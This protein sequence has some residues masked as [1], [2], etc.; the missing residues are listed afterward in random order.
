[1]W[2]DLKPSDW[3]AILSALIAAVSF[4]LSRNT[5]RRQQTLQLESFRLQR[6][7]SLVAWANSTIV[8]IADAQRHCRDIKNGLLEPQDRL[9]AASE[10]RT[11]LSVALDTGRLFFPNQPA[12]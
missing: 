9:K 8:A 2:P 3:L 12:V 5:V 7:N 4:I 6:D 10:L 11:R 1:M